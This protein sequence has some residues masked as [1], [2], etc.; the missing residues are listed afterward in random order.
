[1]IDSAEMSPATTQD[2]RIVLADWPRLLSVEL[3]AI[4]NHRHKLPGMRKWGGKIVF[5]HK[6]NDARR[7]GGTDG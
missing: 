1:M 3:A 5:D 2:G 4:R 7:E 6:A